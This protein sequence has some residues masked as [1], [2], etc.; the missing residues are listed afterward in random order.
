MTVQLYAL[1]TCPHCMKTKQFLNQQGIAYD[2]VDVDLAE[3]EIA[4]RVLAEVQQLTGQ[5]SF[6]VIRINDK[7]IL[8]FHPEQIMETLQNEK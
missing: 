4:D 5:Q 2:L 3:A 8:G 1:S 6:P 7:V